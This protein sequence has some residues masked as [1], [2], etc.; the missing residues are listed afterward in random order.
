M[1][2][3]YFSGFRES[4]LVHFK[5]KTFHA[6]ISIFSFVS[7]CTQLLSNHKTSVLFQR[8]I[9]GEGLSEGRQLFISLLHMTL[10]AFYNG[11]TA[12]FGTLAHLQTAFL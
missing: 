8:L 10:T 3:A 4:S 11:L 7:Y 12:A 2:Q 6:E 9:V 5:M 1:Y